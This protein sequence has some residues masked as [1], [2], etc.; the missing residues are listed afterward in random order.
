MTDST[1]G[2][3]LSRRRFLKTSVAMG[4]GLV[5]NLALGPGFPATA[6]TDFAPNAFIRIDRKGL[7]TLVMPQVE[8]GQGIYTAQA[9]LL[10]E[11]LEVA[12]DDVKL[13]HAPLHE[14][15]YAHPMLRRQ[16]TGGSTSI[17]AFWT[18]LRTA[19]ATARTLLIQA[20]AKEWNS[21]PKTCRAEDGFVIA[22]SGKRRA[23]G[24]LVDIAAAL[25]P[26]SPET[27][28]LKSP[29]DF[30]LLGTSTRRLDTPGKVNGT[31]KYGIDAFPAGTKIAAIAISPVLGGRPK[32]VNEQAALAIKGV[33][34]V[35]LTD[36]AVAVVADHTG[37]AKKGWRPRRSSGTTVPTHR[38]PALISFG[39]WIRNHASPVPSRVAK[40]T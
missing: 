12:L 14:A 38:S 18:P 39:V 27:V 24:E 25:P 6:A 34:Q 1:L 5:L 16:V 35:V 32:S 19:G 10:A 8:M 29:R 11:E 4:G 23:F 17:R 20:A 2:P 7:V 21:D 9:M 31:I 22:E 40:A 13:E 37:A 30:K 36:S 28:T 3:Q 15:L 33:H 26:P